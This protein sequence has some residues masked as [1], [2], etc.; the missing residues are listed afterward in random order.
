MIQQI[1]TLIQQIDAMSKTGQSG[2]Q[3]LGLGLLDSIVGQQAAQTPATA[4]QPLKGITMS[5]R[6]VDVRVIDGRVYHENLEFL[7]DDV[8]VRSRGSVGF[9]ETL[10]VEIEVPIQQ[11]WVGDKPALK[12]LVGQVLKIP[13]QGTF[14]QPKI[15][16]RVVGNFIAQA[17][18]SA[19]SGAIEGELNKALDKLFKPR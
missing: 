6:T 18:Q 11:K 14:N 10:A 13:V 5:E 1:A 8:P 7:I 4:A 9:D 16:E 12:G 15:D 19:A 3:G 17:A 2:G